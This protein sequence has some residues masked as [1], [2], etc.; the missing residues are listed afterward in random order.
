M[1]PEKGQGDLI[2]CPPKNK[3]ATADHYQQQVNDMT[4]EEKRRAGWW[5]SWLFFKLD[6]HESTCRWRRFVRLVTLGATP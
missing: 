6:Q 3:Q 1:E 4:P 2:M 5:F